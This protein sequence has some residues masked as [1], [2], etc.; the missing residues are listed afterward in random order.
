MKLYTRL[1][2]DKRTPEQKVT[3]GIRK[4]VGSYKANIFKR[5]LSHSIF[6]RYD[7]VNQ[8]WFTVKRTY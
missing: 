3:D 6:P 8:R 2:G 5:T 7:E 1:F 4:Q